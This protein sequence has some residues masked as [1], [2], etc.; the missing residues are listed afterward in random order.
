[1]EVVFYGNITK[2]TNGEKAFTPKN[3]STLRTLIDELSCHYGEGF[4]S[5]INGNETCLLLVNNIGTALSGGLDTPLNPD[6]KIEI[7]PFV[8][9]G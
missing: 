6:D 8:E 9:A 2:H 1:M 5:F 4:E 3:H 7:L